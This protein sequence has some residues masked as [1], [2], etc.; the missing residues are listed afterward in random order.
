MLIKSKDKT[1]LDCSRENCRK[2]ATLYS[3]NNKAQFL[4][5][6]N[7]REGFCLFYLFKNWLRK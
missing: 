5:K 3:V 2:L 6:E 1:N 7:L 4:C